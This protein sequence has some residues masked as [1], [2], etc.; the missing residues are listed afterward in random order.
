MVESVCFT[1]VF[2]VILLL[3]EIDVNIKT[4]SL[5][6]MACGSGQVVEV[7]EGCHPHLEIQVDIL[8]IQFPDFPL[9][10]NTDVTYEDSEVTVL[11]QNAA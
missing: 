11:D 4:V 7:M 2:D 1:L 3:Q 8:V 6:L 9:N 10:L 5:C